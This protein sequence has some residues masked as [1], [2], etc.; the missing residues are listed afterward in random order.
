MQNS[1]SLVPHKTRKGFEMLKVEHALNCEFLISSLPD[2]RL[3]KGFKYFKC[4]LA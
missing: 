3:E 4:N 1:Q 2:S